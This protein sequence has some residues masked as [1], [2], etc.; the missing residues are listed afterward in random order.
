MF[1]NGKLAFATH[2]SDYKLTAPEGTQDIRE[3]STAYL[4]GNGSYNIQS[5]ELRDC[6]EDA[7]AV[8]VS[9][10]ADNSKKLFL[11]D[12]TYELTNGTDLVRIRLNTFKEMYPSY[13]ED[14]NATDGKIYIYDSKY[15]SPA[16]A[17]A[18]GAACYAVKEGKYDVLLPTGNYRLTFLAEEDDSY[19]NVVEHPINVGEITDGYRDV[20]MN[21]LKKGTVTDIVLDVT[22]ENSTID[23]TYGEKMNPINIAGYVKNSGKVGGV[24]SVALAEGSEAVK[25]IELDDTKL[26]GTPM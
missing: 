23:L 24:K 14:N 11:P 8:K 9:T 13:V 16:E 6:K 12:C 5:E 22:A 20:D 3:V 4:N 25:G 18:A 26:N 1:L 17:Y 21:D 7:P 15:S 10:D 19:G 2:D